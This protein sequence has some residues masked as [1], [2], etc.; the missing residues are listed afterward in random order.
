VPG[1]GA[2]A[3]AAQA[4][5]D[6]AVLAGLLQDSDSQALD[7]WQAHEAALKTRLPPLELRRLS[8]AMARF[9]FDAALDV[10]HQLQPAADNPPDATTP[11]DNPSMGTLG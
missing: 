8:T 10:L 7:W 4:P 6:L 2:T 9:D 5:P 3:G 11:L 1:P